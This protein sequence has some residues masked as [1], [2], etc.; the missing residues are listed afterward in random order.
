MIPTEVIKSKRNQNSLSQKEI[1]DFIDGYTN[2]NIPDYQMSAWLMAVFLNGMNT[3]ETIHLTQAMLDSG[4]KMDFSS[5]F[6][7]DKHSTGGVG[8]KTSLI[9][10]PIVAACGVPVP[11]MSGRGLGHTGG[12]LDKLESIPGFQVNLDLKA[13]H[14]MV[15][16]HGLCFVG[17][18]EEICPADKKIYA[19]R[20]VTATVESLPLICASIMSKKIAEG[21]K[22]LVLDVKVGSGAF[23]KT[24]EDAEALA[25]GLLSI[26]KGHNIKAKALL[27]D[28]SQ[29]LGRFV[30]NSLEVHECLSLLRSEPLVGYDS[31]SY[32]DTL[33][34]SLQLASQMVAI[35]LSIDLEEAQQ[36]TRKVLDNGQAY[37]VFAQTCARQGGKIDRLPPLG[38]SLS[39]KASETGYLQSYNGEQI[40]LAGIEVNAGRKKSSDPIDPCSGFFI[41]KKLGDLV[42]AGDPIFEVFP[43]DA[44]PQEVNAAIERLNRSYQLSE[45]KVI[46]PELIYNIF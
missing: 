34:L 12:T 24:K 35:G 2:G 38:P 39:V 31:Y 1:F 32:A 30:G 44:R 36:R 27:T 10:A 17:Q 37:E 7:V 41:H 5:I 29:P 15:K 45:Q 22:G 8:D 40:G 3:E 13:F 19:L 11:M 16:N 9:L 43:G 33:E 4:K 26:A 14:D 42:K 28:M 25:Q 46:A 23:M 18:T 6:P 20:D 21:I